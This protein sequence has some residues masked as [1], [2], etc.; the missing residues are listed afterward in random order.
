MN[1]FDIPIFKK[2][3]ELR[4]YFYVCLKKFPRYDRYALGARCEEEISGLMEAIMAASQ[5][6][7]SEKLPYLRLGSRKLNLLRADLLFSKDIRAI[8]GKVYATLAHLLDEIG[9]MLG[10]WERF[11]KGDKETTPA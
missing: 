8:D 3:Y 5:L 9:K 11:A 4:K 1:T 10:G 6:P 7:K 2:I